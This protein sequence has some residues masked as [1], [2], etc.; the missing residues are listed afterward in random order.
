MYILWILQEM[1]DCLGKKTLH[2]FEAAAQGSS[3]PV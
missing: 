2:S 1:A 3:L